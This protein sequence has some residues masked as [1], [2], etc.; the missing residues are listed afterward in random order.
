MAFV[1]MMGCYDD[2]DKM[3]LDDYLTNRCD[4]GRISLAE[5]KVTRQL[6]EAAIAITRLIRVSGIETDLG[7]E[8][9]GANSDGD[10]QKALDVMAEEII[11]EHLQNTAAAYVLSE[12]QDAPIAL[13]SDEAADAAS[14]QD[15]HMMVAIDPLDGSSNIAVNVTVGTIFSIMPC[16]NG[17]M[18]CRGRDQLAAGFFAYGPQ[19]T[20]I[21]AFA[22]DTAPQC[23][24]LDERD[25]QFVAMDDLVRIPDHSNEYA[26]NAAY[27]AHWFSPV[28]SWMAEVLAGKE[29]AYSKSFRMRWVG[30][31]VADAWRI[32]RRGGVFLYPGDHRKGYENG[33]LRLVYEANPISFL[34]EKAGGRAVNGSDRILD[35]LP[36]DLHQRT[37]LI[38][39]SAAEVDHLIAFHRNE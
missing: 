13:S 22:R 12:E 9:G 7:A 23:F 11:I 24:V 17:P 20:L 19:T 6:A 35:L 1:M 33:R 3:R 8:T 5:A 37:A 31:M 28:K 16:T 39:G 32:F 34:T 36:E 38:F 4:D 2:G 27:A 14:S 21:L 30:S 25:G 26:I 18:P 15:Q 29:G 10:D